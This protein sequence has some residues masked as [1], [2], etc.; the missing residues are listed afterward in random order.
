MAEMGRRPRRRDK[1]PGRPAPK[2]SSQNSQ[3]RENGQETMRDSRFSIL[4]PACL[5]ALALAAGLL[6]TGLSGAGPAA[7]QAGRFA[8]SVYV[9]DEAISQ[10]E[11]DQRVKFLEIL[12]VPGDPRAEA[13]KSL[14]ED[15][16]RRQAARADAITVSEAQITKGMAEFA[17]RA[18]LELDP[19][20]QAI[21]EG[22]VAA[23]SFRDFVHAGIAWREVVRARFVPKIRVSEAEIDRAM[24]VAAQRGAGPR[25]LLSEILIP[26]TPATAVDARAL[27]AELSTSI[28]SEAEFA[29]AARAHSAAASRDQGGQVDWIPLTNLPPQLR[30]VAV[31]L[32][33]GAVSPPVA[34]PGAIAL[35]RLRGLEQGGEIDPRRV[36]VDYARLVISGG[37]QEAARISAGIDTCDDLYRFARGQPAGTLVRETRT[38][39]SV[40]ADIAAELARL[41][42]N[43]ISTARMQGASPVLVMLCRRSATVA[44]N[45]LSAAEAVEIAAADIAPA[46][47]F[48]IGDVPRINLDLGFGKGPTRAQLRE[49]LINQRLGG[50]AD[51]YLARLRAEAII[52]RP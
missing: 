51:S 27:A 12:R 21:A 47:P 28:G 29:R 17:G 31:G 22:G 6:G 52:R 45:A 25:V 1:A 39:A 42:D 11:I 13:E 43:E 19:F 16:L 38:M 10:Y 23:E 49:E 50:M 35:I 40:P 34:V 20:L 3:S 4:R 15:R 36:T 44:A 37:R 30:Q 33:N 2:Q 24:S 8:P 5:A 26:V 41:D 14:I 9:N 48:K 46:V 7:A 32:S 18:N